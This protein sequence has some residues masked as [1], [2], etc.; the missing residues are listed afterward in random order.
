MS[1]TATTLGPNDSLVLTVPSRTLRGQNWPVTITTG[2]TEFHI[3]CGCRASRTRRCWHVAFVARLLHAD[4]D[5]RWHQGHAVGRWVDLDCD[6]L[7]PAWIDR[8]IQGAIAR[9]A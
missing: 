9:A 1:A 2:L 4:G 3:T 5:F 7:E 6:D 8:A